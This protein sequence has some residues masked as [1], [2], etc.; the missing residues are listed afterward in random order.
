MDR[1]I[2]RLLTVLLL[3]AAA[4]PVA[5]AQAGISRKQQERIQ[6][7]KEKKDKVNVK[8]EEKRLLKKHL[9]NQDKATRKRMKR[10]KRGAARHGNAGQ[11]DPFLR[12]WFGHKH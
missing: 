2:I 10:H 9:S 12:R 6:R 5:S 1:L 8:K 3:A 11:R 4:V 7:K